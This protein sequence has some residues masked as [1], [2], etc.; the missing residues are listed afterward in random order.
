MEYRFSSHPEFKDGLYKGQW[1]N[2]LPHGRCVY[3]CSVYTDVGAP[4]Q[5]LLDQLT[6]TLI[7]LSTPNYLSGCSNNFSLSSSGEFTQESTGRLYKGGFKDGCFHGDGEMLWFSDKD[8]RKK[9]IGEF[10]N[11][12]MN[13]HGEMK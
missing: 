2:A 3:V 13:G 5:Y 9:Y 7:S 1:R 4:W 8:S 10:R 6:Y 11:G 12:Q